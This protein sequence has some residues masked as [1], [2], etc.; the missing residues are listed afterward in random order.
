MSIDL[1]PVIILVH[2]T[3]AE[4]AAWIQPDSDFSNNLRK[5][6]GNQIEVI[7]FS[8]N[9]KNSHDERYI[10]SQKLKEVLIKTNIDFPER[11]KIVIGHSHGGNL[12]IY[13]LRDSGISKNFEL[14]TLGT[15]FLNYKVRDF[16]SSITL[17]KILLTVFMGIF[18]TVAVTTL[19]VELIFRLLTY[20]DL[21][22]YL[23]NTILF[24][25]GASLLF[26]SGKL[27][28]VTLYKRFDKI[29]KELPNF[30]KMTDKQYTS[31]YEKEYGVLSIIHDV[32]EVK[33]LFGWTYHAISSLFNLY[34]V[35]FKILSKLSKYAAIIL[36]LYIIPAAFLDGI[37]KADI[38]TSL[39]TQIVFIICVSPIVALLCF[40]YFTFYL[41]F[42]ILLLKSNPA[43]YGWENM[44]YMMFIHFAPS[45]I[46]DN[47]KDIQFQSLPLQSSDLL[48]LRHSIYN[49]SRIFPIIGDWIRRVPQ[50]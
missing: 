23:I 20:L 6:L 27:F 15:P 18:F 43:I 28:F 12:A 26:G 11:R 14:V 30:I 2:G 36:L 5:E 49:D 42:A 24:L 19:S 7:S 33:H 21:N 9:G 10:E 17:H 32:D 45:T 34:D 47:I 22:E 35:S 25:G 50:S 29:E 8:W 3:F 48:V 46:T 39:V 13:A 38:Q 40:P 4:N 44:K 1:H 31:S 16:A 41:A 37:L